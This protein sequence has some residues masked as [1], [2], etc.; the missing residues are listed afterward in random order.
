MTKLGVL[1][2]V[3]PVV[4]GVSATQ[5]DDARHAFSFPLTRYARDEAMLASDHLEARRWRKA[6]EVL[7]RMLIDQ[8]N[9]VLPDSYRATA[10]LASSHAAHPGAAQWARARLF[11]AR[12]V[13]HGARGV[14]GQAREVLPVE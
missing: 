1:L 5:E 2:V 8:D 10:H 13:D 4:A 11:E 9:A 3:L 7:Q 12:A 14:G 6:I